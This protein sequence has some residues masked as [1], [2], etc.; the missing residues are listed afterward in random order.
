MK[1]YR[2]SCE[3]SSET[4][5]LRPLTA[6]C[7]PS[8]G[9]FTALACQTQRRQAGRLLHAVAL[10]GRDLDRSWPGCQNRGHGVSDLIQSLR[11]A[12]GCGGAWSRRTERCCR[13]AD[14][15]DEIG[16]AHV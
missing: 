1:A 3:I 13:P 11:T 9:G 8:G 10:A 5:S 4:I 16:R 14:G 7:Q 12:K 15:I 2:I 6:N